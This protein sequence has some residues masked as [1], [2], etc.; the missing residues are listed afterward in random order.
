[1]TLLAPDGGAAKSSIAGGPDRTP[2]CAHVVQR[3]CHGVRSPRSLVFTLQRRSRGN[4]RDDDI[5]IS[6][7]RGDMDGAIA[8]ALKRCLPLDVSPGIGDR[9][10]PRAPPR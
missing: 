7:H 10:A 1:L 8:E 9:A 4:P 2:C 3:G 5:V 6:F